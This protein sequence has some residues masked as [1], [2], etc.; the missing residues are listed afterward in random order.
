MPAETPEQLIQRVARRIV[1]LR[2]AADRTQEELA[3]ALATSVQYV[4]RLEVGE[5]LTL[6]S[7]AKIARALGVPAIALLESPES[8]PTRTRRGR[9]RKTPSKR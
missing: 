2:H 8:K 3:E 7:V 1:E 6:A 4:S 5:N 9:P